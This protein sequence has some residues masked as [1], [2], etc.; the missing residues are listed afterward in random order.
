[1]IHHDLPWRPNVAD[2]V[3]A[4][5]AWLMAVVSPT[6]KVIRNGV[7]LPIVHQPF[8]ESPSMRYLGVR[9]PRTDAVNQFIT[10]NA[11]SGYE[12]NG[13]A[14]TFGVVNGAWNVPGLQYPK[15]AGDIY[16]SAAWVGID[17]G[18]S[19]PPY[20]PEQNNVFQ[21]GTEMDETYAGNGTLTASYY[22]WREYTPDPIVFEMNTNAFD[23]VGCQVFKYITNNRAAGEYWCK[24]YQTGQVAEY[25][26]WVD[27]RMVNSTAEWIVERPFVNGG[28]APLSNYSSISFGSAWIY[29]TTKVF[30]PVF[31]IYPHWSLYQIEM[32]SDS[33]HQELS[34]AYSLNR[35]DGQGIGFEWFNSF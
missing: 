15:V 29:T 27:S 3:A 28:W 1:M 22:I 17:G 2:D 13:Y 6:R 8:R 11:W 33:T 4:Y 18:K 10:N 26:Q 16:Y 12:G 24:D 25:A 20:P 31:S 34:G 35:S 9:R 19:A 14:G 23:Y 5:N 21:S 30:F 7:A 32:L